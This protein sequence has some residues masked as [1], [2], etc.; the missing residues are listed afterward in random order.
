MQYQK[1]S[2]VFVQ[3]PCDWVSQVTLLVS[4]MGHKRWLNK[5]T[6][7]SFLFFSCILVDQVCGIINTYNFIVFSMNDHKLSIVTFHRFD[8]IKMIVN[9]R[10]DA[11]C[12]LF[13]YLRYGI[14]GR[15]KDKFLILDFGSQIASRSRTNGPSNNVN[16]FG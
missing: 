10:S 2:S 16:I 15:D 11:S 5:F 9:E 8:V 14:K 12:F 4:V 3:K 7:L 1:D 13:G 6:I